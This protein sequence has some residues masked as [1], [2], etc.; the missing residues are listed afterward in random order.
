MATKKS[1]LRY[2]VWLVPG[3]AAHPRLYLAINGRFAAV[4][5]ARCWGL[6]TGERRA[7]VQA[8]RGR[9]VQRD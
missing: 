3:W 1:L 2:R 7:G 4:L 9:F 8:C 5:C 6:G